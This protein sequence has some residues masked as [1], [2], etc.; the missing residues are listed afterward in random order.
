M[1]TKDIA[2]V[3]S[4]LTYHY[5]GLG[6]LVCEKFAA[7]GSNVAINYHSNKEAAEQV[8]KKVE[9]YGVKATIIQAV[10]DSGLTASNSC[11]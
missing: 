9:S 5:R 3:I 8:A 1:S 11:I 2:E 6:A 4:A 7:E 10:S